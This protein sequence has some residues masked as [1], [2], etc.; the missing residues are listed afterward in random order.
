MAEY[1]NNYESEGELSDIAEE[2]SDDAEE[3]SEIMEEQS[4]TKEKPSPRSTQPALGGTVTPEGPG[5][6]GR[7]Q[8]CRTIKPPGIPR[9]ENPDNK[10]V[11][12]GQLKLGQYCI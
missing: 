5:T 10:A 6:V 8:A 12:G 11:E 9:E 1:W 3:L 7:K 2:L 4:D